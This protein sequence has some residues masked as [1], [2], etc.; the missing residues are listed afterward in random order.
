MNPDSE[1]YHLRELMPASGRMFAKIVSKPQQSKV[2]D[3]PF[4]VPWKAGLREIRINFDL[5]QELDRAERDLLFLRSLSWVLGIRWFKPDWQRGVAVAGGLGAIAELSQ[6][7]A[8]GVLVA[9][10]LSAIALR[11]IWRNPRSTKAEIEADEAAI[12]VALRRGYSE[13]EAARSL[14]F[15]IEAVAK[16]EGRS[17]LNFTELIRTQHLKAIAKLSPVAVPESVKNE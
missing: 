6:G 4:P 8:I 11:Q 2:I 12:K 3:L 5:W 13:I 16:V 10:G 1:I 17:T 15:A 9:G 14:F 7:D